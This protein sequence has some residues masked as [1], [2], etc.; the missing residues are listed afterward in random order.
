MNAQDKIV[1]SLNQILKAIMS[2]VNYSQRI[3][4][5]K[6]EMEKAHMAGHDIHSS[7]MGD[8][9]AELDNLVWE[10]ENSPRGPSSQTS[11]TVQPT[12]LPQL[13]H[14]D[15]ELE[16]YRSRTVLSQIP[17]DS[18]EGGS[19]RPALPDPS[20]NFDHWAE[21]MEQN[22]SE[23]A[24][25]SDEES[26]ESK[27][28]VTFPDLGYKKGDRVKGDATYAFC[29]LRLVS[30]Y[31]DMYVGKANKPRVR[32]YFE[33]EAFLGAQQWDF[34]YLYNTA[35]QS[36][37]PFV[38]LLTSQLQKFLQIINEGLNINLTIPV[39]HDGDFNIS[40]ARFQQQS[41]PC[42]RYLGQATD[43]DTFDNLATAIPAPDPEDNA[44]KLV[45]LD[46]KIFQDTWKAMK[47]S[48]GVV[49]KKKKKD[50][51]HMMRAAM[52]KG[53]GHTTKRVQRYLGLRTKLANGN[54]FTGINMSSFAYPCIMLT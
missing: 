51:K 46:S 8:L 53:W 29:P 36:G 50:Q 23:E 40:F 33:L 30:R 1:I 18:L 25:D 42:P 37:K 54:E 26:A 13:G 47:N 22:D 39:D 14:P 24:S 41:G 49:P 32:P 34:F 3:A 10:S 28:L 17:S 16:Y 19:A 7:T 15:S 45:G 52:H 6:A 38:L 31:A 44:N 2:D 11:H 21:L 12:P 27:D 4:A 5:V 43:L 35:D 48:T 9:M 20:F